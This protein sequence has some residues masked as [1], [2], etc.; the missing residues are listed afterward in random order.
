MFSELRASGSIQYITIP[1][2]VTTITQDAFIGSGLVYVNLPRTIVSIEQNAFSET[3]SY[4]RV[5]YSDDKKTVTGCVLHYRGDGPFEFD[6]IIPDGVE[7]IADNAFHNSHLTSIRFPASL[8]SIGANAFLDCIYLTSVNVSACIHLQS[9]GE[10][11]FKNCTFTSIDLF[12]CDNIKFIGESAFQ[13]CSFQSIDLSVCYHLTSIKRSTFYDSELNSIRFPIAIETIHDSAFFNCNI[14]SIVFPYTVESIGSYAFKGCPLSAVTFSNSLRTI[15]NSAFFNCPLTSI[16][17]PDNLKSIGEDAFNHTLLDYVT[18]PFIIPRLVTHIGIHAFRVTRVMNIHLPVNMVIYVNTA[19]LYPTTAIF[20]DRYSTMQY[21]NVKINLN[22]TLHTDSKVDIFGEP[23][24]IPLNVIIANYTIPV[25]ALY[26]EEH[27]CGLIEMQDD[28]DNIHVRFANSVYDLDLTDAY[29]KS[30]IK[31]VYALE[32]SLCD[33]FDCS[34]AEPFADYHELTY[35]T[36]SDFGRLALNC[37]AHYILGHIDSVLAITNDVSFMENMLSLSDA[38]T[39]VKNSSLGRFKGV[40]SNLSNVGYQRFLK[41]NIHV[42]FLSDILE[43]ASDG[44]TNARLAELLVQSLLLKG[45]DASNNLITSVI[46][47]TIPSDPLSLAHIVSQVITQDL[48]RAMRK[49][50]RVPVLLP[51]YP[52]DIIYMNIKLKRPTVIVDIPSH[53]NIH[54]RYTKEI[55]YVIQLTLGP[56]SNINPVGDW[57]G[58]F[59]DSLKGWAYPS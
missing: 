56:S 29:K 47:P 22:V 1:E 23:F 45:L 39:E 15:G 11:A 43:A 48:N 28:L 20:P 57:I 33:S 40:S 26:D 7:T 3:V 19:Q 59:K 12:L 9:I 58:A 49:N 38:I 41:N 4:A 16:T 31:L 14:T 21:G 24:D 8:R 35:T 52:G 54:N 27:H 42:S 13:S 36:Q 51:F 44:T 34:G 18:S 2:G 25:D 55:N 53:E 6:I 46:Q 10:N 17:L 50:N 30:A 32:R 5:S 37:F